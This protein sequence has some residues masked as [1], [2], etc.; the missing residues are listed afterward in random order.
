MRLDYIKTGQIN[1]KDISKEFER[2]LPYV[3]FLSH[4]ANSPSYS[5]PESSLT[6]PS[7]KKNLKRIQEMV[8]K[9]VSDNLKYIIVIGIGGSN[10]GAKAVYDALYGH[11]DL[12]QPDRR[13]KIIFVDTVNPEYIHHLK[14]FI[15]EN[16]KSPDEV[17]INAISKS[18]G[19][20][21]MN[22]NLESIMEILREKFPTI[23]S[24]LVVTTD[25]GSKL[26]H[27]AREQNIDILTVPEKVGGRFSVLSA[28]GLF[29]LLASGVAIDEL[30]EGAC[31]TY[32]KCL[33]DD[34]NKNYAAASAILHYL[35]H[36][37]RGMV[38]NTLFVFHP[39]LESLG[40]WYRQ[41][42]AESLGKEKDLEGNTINTGITPSVSVGSDL[43]SMAQLYLDGPRDKMTTFLSTKKPK[44][45]QHSP[46]KTIFSGLVPE[47]EGSSMGTV[48][49][50][51]LD[52]TKKAFSKKNLPFIEITL[53]DIGP[54]SLGAFLQF[55]MIETMYLGKL[56]GINT[57]DQPGIWLYKDEAKKILRGE[58]E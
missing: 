36:K 57:F 26:W 46:Q 18:G 23:L 38:N 10:L 27:A 32:E 22:V 58:Q 29:P 35:H 19:T 7:D 41:L 8:D 2:L 30:L 51:M 33:S 56:F 50:A 6:L 15:D 17:L 14:K 53:D 1:E 47:V 40:K 11:F 49:N 25:K 48:H 20:I 3:E 39:E 28:V 9:K 43:H 45:E 16:I 12:L 34:I 54:R 42:I 24:R 21:E 37:E 52:G 5:S 4:V 13:A 31:E 55:K 44:N